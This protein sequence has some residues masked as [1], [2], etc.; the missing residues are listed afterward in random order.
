MIM[1]RSLGEELFIYLLSFV[2]IFFYILVESAADKRR[3]DNKSPT[4]SVVTKLT[5]NM[6]RL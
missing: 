2:Y 5:Q 6:A 3:L 1:I 4:K